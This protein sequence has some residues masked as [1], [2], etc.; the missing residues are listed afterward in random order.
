MLTMRTSIQIA[1]K[2]P[3]LELPALSGFDRQA[4]GGERARRACS[5]SGA[6]C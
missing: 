2:S 3:P 4:R 1:G 6:E 5:M